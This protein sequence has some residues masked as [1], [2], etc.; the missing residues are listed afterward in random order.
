MG[1]AECGMGFVLGF[2]IL[3][4]LFLPKQVFPETKKKKTKI[5]KTFT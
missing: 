4:D 1:Q 5:D 3:Y 2:W